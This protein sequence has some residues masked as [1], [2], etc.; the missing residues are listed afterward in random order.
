MAEEEEESKRNSTT[1]AALFSAL[2]SPVAVERQQNGED[3]TTR[4]E[5]TKSVPKIVSEIAPETAEV[6]DDEADP[7]DAIMMGIGDAM[8]GE[9][10]TDQ[11]DKMPSKEEG[12]FGDQEIELISTEAYPDDILA[13]AAKLK[14]KKE[15]P[16]INHSKIKYDSFRKIFC[17]EPAQLTDV[18]EGEVGDLRLELDGMGQNCPKPVQKWSQCGIPA[19]TL[20]VIQR[21]GYEK[22]T[23][24]QSQAVMSGSG[25]AKTGSRQT[26]A[27]LL[28]MCQHIKDQHL[29]EQ[30]EGPI[31]LIMTL[32]RELAVQIHKECKP[33]LK[34]LNLMCLRW[35]TH[36]RPD[37][38]RS[39]DYRVYT[40]PHDRLAGSKLQPC[41]E[42]EKSNIRCAG[43]NVRHGFRAAGD[44]NY[45]TGSPNSV[46]LSH[47]T[48]PDGSNCAENSTAP[49]RDRGWSTQCG[50]ARGE[51]RFAMIMINSA[52]F[53]NYSV[54]YTI[55][56]RMLGRLYL[57]TALCAYSSQGGSNASSVVGSSFVWGLRGFV[58]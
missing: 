1:A 30:L 13:T 44:E 52:G 10:T 23:S 8:A 6:E 47:I 35:L 43:S 48:P 9:T 12:L 25:L 29:L 11:K 36:Q 32:T 21:L 54:T 22:P 40:W 42:F 45:K 3:P 46:I 18:T 38:T 58:P 16:T 53:W 49:S 14:E 34:A 7:L 2:D 28:R 24:I 15:L 20:D 50:S 57:S 55:R 33:F 27:F 37:Q 41:H 26:I 51:S 39:R 17:V 56:T 4:V 31:S 19:Q 5:E